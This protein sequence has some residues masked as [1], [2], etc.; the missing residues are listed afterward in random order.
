MGDINHSKNVL[1]QAV[2]LPLPMDMKNSIQVAL[3][4]INTK[5]AIA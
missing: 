5:R 2:S 4:N 3:N 1:E